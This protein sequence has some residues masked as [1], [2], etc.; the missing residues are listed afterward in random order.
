VEVFQDEGEQGYY[1]IAMTTADDG[2]GWRVDGLQMH[3]GLPVTATAT[4]GEG[5]TS[6]FSSPFNMPVNVRN[7]TADS[8]E[9]PAVHPNY[10]NPFNPLTTIR[11][12]VAEPC[13][14]TLKVYDI[15]GQE[16]AVVA[17]GRFT[18]GSHEVRFDASGLSSGIYVYRIRMGDFTASRKMAVVE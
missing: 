5:N 7:Q 12:N 8:P 9:K 3:P 2:G 11:F 4:D 15:R 18:A 17:D 14:V 6:A 13:R 10:P 1:F 16:V